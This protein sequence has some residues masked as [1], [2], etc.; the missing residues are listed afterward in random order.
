MRSGRED[1]SPYVRA[2]RDRHQRAV[3]QTARWAVEAADAGDFKTALEWLN[4]LES[5]DGGL[6]GELAAVRQ[7]CME[8]P[9]FR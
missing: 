2:R 1:R 7:R 6:S 3:A 4:V 9:S 8:E 5:V